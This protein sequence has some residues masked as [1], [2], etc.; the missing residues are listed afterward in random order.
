MYLTK[1]LFVEFT[2]SPKLARWHVNN[3]DTHKSIQEAKYGAM[4]GM[5][6]GQE[7]EDMVLASYPDK[8]V[9]TIDTENMW[10]N[11]HKTYHDRTMKALEDNPEI[12][13][14]PSFLIG[15]IF[16]KCD[17]LIK[18]DAGTYDLIEVK[19]KNS[20]RKKTK[21]EPLLD[22]LIADVSIQRR[23]LAQ[24]LWEKF[25]GRCY[26]AFLNKEYSKNGEIDP[27]ELSK[28][29]E[30]SEEVLED[31]NIEEILD[32]MKKTL[33][34]NEEAFTTYY[35]YDGSDYLSYFW[36]A[37][38][39]KSI[40][41]ISGC[42]AKKKL[43]FYEQ[44][45]ILIEE[46][47]EFDIEFLRKSNGESSKAQGF[48]ELR[49][50]G[51]QT[52]DTDSIRKQFEQL[53]F[54]LYFY[55]Y[56]TISRPVPLFDGTTPWQQIVVQYSLHKME[57]DGSISHHEGLLEPGA[58]TNKDLL[59]KMIDAMDQGKQ[60]TRI[61]WNQWFE[62]SRNTEWAK[63]YPEYEEQLLSINRQTFDLMEIFRQQLF[64]HRDF[65]GSASIKKVLPV[66][67]DIRYDDLEV[68]NGWIASNLLRQ[69]IVGE[70][71]DTEI[72]HTKQELL[73]YCEQDTRAMVAIYQKLLQSIE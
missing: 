34:L 66:L 25:S 12:L 45:K 43:A 35:P 14:Q 68:S 24:V 59:Q 10:S 30:V 6:I 65:E 5:R 62:K 21:A 56:E 18:N 57:E 4:D 31:A 71:K 48:V 33:V 52:I 19:A 32:I 15:D 67:T 3:K 47:N 70:L 36:E 2:S 26:L 38:P 44:N 28:Q 49:K 23:V 27:Q 73:K 39:K 20:I 42:S 16:V 9:T 63:L 40:R 8:P 37:A 1:S 58:T 41:S 55:D 50:Q 46:L 11:R 60:W 29:E 51:P 13:Y 61:V 17:M 64:F 54:P 72:E 7:V 22:E 69:M 53:Q